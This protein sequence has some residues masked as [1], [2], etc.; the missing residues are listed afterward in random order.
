MLLRLLLLLLEILKVLLLAEQL[1]LGLAHGLVFEFE[2]LVVVVIIEVGLGGRRYL[3][4]ASM[5]VDALVLDRVDGR[6]GERAL[7]LALLFVRRRATAVVIVSGGRTCI[8]CACSHW[9]AVVV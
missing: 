8:V 9:I 5:M 2:E 1:V 3:Q 6:L 4:H 7:N